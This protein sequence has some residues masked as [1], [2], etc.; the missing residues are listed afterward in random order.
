MQVHELKITT[1]RK[2]RKRIGRGGIRGTYS[3]RGIKGQG[4]RSGAK[5]DPLFEGGRSTLIE[6][7][8]KVRGFKSPHPKRFPV[9]IGALETAF[10]ADET[11][12]MALLVE[13]RVIDPSV[14]KTG[15]KILSNGTLSKA[16]I[17]SADIPVSAGAAQ[18]IEK[19]GG[20]IEEA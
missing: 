10:K 5:I 2:P 14:L 9:S 7:T 1:K 3:G 18:A 19:A 12:T 15:A 4:A 11:V 13:R 16:L 6:R 17:I 8:K 20:K